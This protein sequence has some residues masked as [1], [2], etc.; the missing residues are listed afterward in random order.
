MKVVD[1]WILFFNF[2]VTIFYVINLSFAFDA[3]VRFHSGHNNSQQQKQNYNYSY[4]NLRRVTGY[5]LNVSNPH[6]SF[7]V[8]NTSLCIKECLLSAGV[9]K[10][11]NIQASSSNTDLYECEVLSTDIYRSA[12]TS[13]VQ[14][15]DAIH[16]IISVS[17]FVSSFFDGLYVSCLCNV[18]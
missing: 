4:I 10:S 7:T 14:R 15:N 17:L 5:K 18:L 1:T 2:L 9:C 3:G 16:Y 13:L 6:A 11:F 8:K 12:S